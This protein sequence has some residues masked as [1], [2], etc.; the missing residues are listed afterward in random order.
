M[1]VTTQ[2]FQSQKEPS[3]KPSAQSNQRTTLPQLR[4]A[5]QLPQRGS[6]ERLYHPP[7]Y[8]LKF[9]A[10]GDFHRPYERRVPFIV[11]VE[12]RGRVIQPTA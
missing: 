11:P 9:N 10:A 3:D 5:Q 12:N 8:S 2:K 6:R 7:D 4:C 1:N